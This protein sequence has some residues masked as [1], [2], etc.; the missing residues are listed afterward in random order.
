[1]VY[2]AENGSGQAAIIC[3][4]SQSDIDTTLWLVENGKRSSM[5]PDT[6]YY[7]KELA[8]ESLDEGDFEVW[9]EFHSANEVV[10]CVTS[11]DFNEDTICDIRGG[12]PT[13]KSHRCAIL[14]EL[15]TL[16]V[17]PSEPTQTDRPNILELSAVA[18]PASIDLQGE[19]SA[20]SSSSRLSSPSRPMPPS[21]QNRG[22]SHPK[23]TSPL[24]S[25]CGNS[26]S[27]SPSS[28]SRPSSRCGPFRPT[29]PSSPS[30]E[31]SRP[32]IP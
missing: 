18:E 11:G 1:V 32:M 20:C 7:G 17:D 27:P 24:S 25:S 4:D 13:D 15:P 19:L 29:S 31:P 16:F 28:A 26:S 2:G 12:R 14:K 3:C 9:I 30:D 10:Q 5:I 8:G 6:F 23:S 21:S 22:L